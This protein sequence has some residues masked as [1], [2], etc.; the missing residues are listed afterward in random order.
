MRMVNLL[1]ESLE[2][3]VLSGLVLRNHLELDF[4]LE[5]S[6]SAPL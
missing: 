6:L 3:L 1:P 2:V 5:V 4:V